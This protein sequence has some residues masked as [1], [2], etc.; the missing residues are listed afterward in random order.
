LLL[1]VLKQQ[2]KLGDSGDCAS[3]LSNLGA[4]CIWRGNWAGAREYLLEALQ[5]CEEHRLAPMQ[6]GLV[7][8]NLAWVALETNDL[9][10]AEV[11]GR[12]A[13]DATRAAA[14]HRLEAM[15]L[16]HF[17]R[18]A[19]R[20]ADLSAARENLQAA[21]ARAVA[22]TD[23]PLQLLILGRFAEVLATVGESVAAARI[24][25]FV[26]EHPRTDA[27]V[28]NELRTQLERDVQASAVAAALDLSTLAARIIAETAVAHAPLIAT[29]RIS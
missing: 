16:L 8:C 10:A 15:V 25:R 14:H 2:R 7:L 4:S 12:R 22:T 6:T 28:R 11:Y 29:L 27:D 26:I 9:Q 17:V 5:L 20:R 1:E 23:E 24:R 18:L 19:L 13:L 3:T 21:L